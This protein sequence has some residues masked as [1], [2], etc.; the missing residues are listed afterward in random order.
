MKNSEE[1]SVGPESDPASVSVVL[2]TFNRCE[3]LARVLNALDQQTY[4]GPFEVV[5]VSDGSTDDTN[6]FLASAKTSFDLVVIEQPNSG[7]A[8]ARNRGIEAAKNNLIVF[9]D[10][11]VIPVP[12]LIAE[13]VAAH[14]RAGDGR[15]VAIGPMLSPEDANYSPWVAWEQEKLQ[16]Q[17]VGLRS[18]PTAYYRQFYTGNASVL[19]HHL[20]KSGGFDADLR[21]A[22]DVELAYRLDRAGLRFEFCPTARG[23]HYAERSFDSWIAMA[24]DYGKTN[25]AFDRSGQDFLLRSLANEFRQRHRY[26]QKFVRTFV[27]RPRA[28]RLAL[29]ALRT[30]VSVADKAGSAQVSANA[31]SAMYG[32]EHYRGMADGLGS[33]S[34][35]LALLDRRGRDEDVFLPVFTLEQTLGHVTHGKNLQ[36]IL[37]P[38]RGLLLGV[39]KV[40]QGMPAW[41]A[42]VPGWSNWTVR[43]GIRAQLS[44]RA[45]VRRTPSA[46]IQALFVHSQVPAVLLVSWLKKLP[47]I[48]SLDA[49]PLQ[50]DSLGASYAHETGPPWIERIKFRLNRRC[51]H[52]ANHLVTWSAWARDGLVADYGV[53]ASKVTVIA[54]GVNPALWTR[55]TARKPDD[56]SIGVLF[57]GGDFERK[58]G[59]ELLEAARLLREQPDVP[60]FDLHIVTKSAIAEDV[61]PVIVYNNMSPN[62]PEL[63]DLFH[64]SDIFCLPTYGDCLPMV[65][66]E[67]GAAELALISTDVGAISEVVRPGETG[68][69][70]EVGDVASLVEALGTLVRDPERRRRYGSNANELVRRDHDARQNAI[71]LVELLADVAGKDLVADWTEPLPQFVAGGSRS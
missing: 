17:Y 49:T 50:Y 23:F 40:E 26:Q 2:P 3:R 57:V 44:L 9:I 62:S 47:S 13:H 68:E 66:A 16:E 65:L 48:V 15:L 5:V 51:F 37:N 43:A 35:L 8:V 45:R 32:L 6:A 56:S 24:Y 63:I 7:P 29:R 59:A 4:E 19:R 58:G 42:R 18:N 36:N 55:T 52:A 46:E 53:E 1:R 71:Q 60:P 54:P 20:E 27:G 28:S 33:A 39:E 34:A 11:D 61:T 41:S 25:V 67:A 38:M 22:E 14:Q 31:L 30:L 21:R 10:D 70:V 69:L 12:D 64:Q